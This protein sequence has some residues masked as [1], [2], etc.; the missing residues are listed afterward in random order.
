MDTELRSPAHFFTNFYRF[1]I[2][3]QFIIDEDR[4]L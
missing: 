1:L 2:Q 3:A 4:M